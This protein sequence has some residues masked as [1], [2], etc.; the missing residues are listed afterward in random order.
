MLEL[1]IGLEFKRQALR[2]Q[3]SRMFHQDGDS[4][5]GAA[6]L[7]LGISLMIPGF[8]IAVPALPVVAVGLAI[9]GLV[10]IFTIV[11]APLGLILL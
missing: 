7:V 8:A 10:L 11:L 2:R 6:L 3:V 5:F 4:Y 9:A 1:M